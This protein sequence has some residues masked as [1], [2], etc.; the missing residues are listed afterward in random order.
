MLISDKTTAFADWEKVKLNGK[1]GVFFKYL[2]LSQGAG[3]L[4]T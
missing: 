2:E 3:Q 4:V 1:N